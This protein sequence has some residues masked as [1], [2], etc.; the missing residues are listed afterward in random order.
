[1][2]LH[3]SGEMYL[4]TILILKNKNQFVRSIDVANT[5]NFSKPSVSRAMKILKESGLITIDAKG[6]IEFTEEGR[7]KAE[8]IYNRHVAFTRFL[9]SIGVSEQQAEEDACRIEHIISDE[10]YECIKEYLL[11]QS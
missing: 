6:Y 9:I 3:E 11:K 8:N 5:M 1:M 10:T 2:D 4:E 7:V